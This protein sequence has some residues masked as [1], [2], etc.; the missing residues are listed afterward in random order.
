M[1]ADASEI[2]DLETPKGTARVHRYPAAGTTDP[3]GVIVLGHGAG[4]G[5]NA[6]DLQAVA[7]AAPEVGLTVILTEQPYRVAGRRSPPPAPTLDVAWQSIID[8][9]QLGDLPLLTG[10]RSSGARVAC[11]TAQATGARGVISLA[12]PLVAPSGKSRQSELDEAGVPVL[13]IQGRSDR[14]GM[15]ESDAARERTVVQV[16]GD[17]GLKKEHAA[18]AATV[19]AWATALIA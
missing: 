5:P 7:Q 19:T 2:L 14:F 15:P 9:L 12:F 18:I 4:G 11:R 16:D 8:Q 17:H 6:P 3:L 1:A 13:V 10:G